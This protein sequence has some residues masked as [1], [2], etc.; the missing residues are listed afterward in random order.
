MVLSLWM[1]RDLHAPQPPHRYRD[2]SPIDS[3]R[4]TT[5]SA[6]SVKLA[7]TGLNRC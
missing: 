2:A 6:S 1:R 3:D 4:V 5:H 7:C